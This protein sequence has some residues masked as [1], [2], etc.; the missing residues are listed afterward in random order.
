M[1]TLMGEESKEAQ[2]SLSIVGRGNH[3]YGLGTRGGG[4]FVERSEPPDK[5]ALL[6]ECVNIYNRV[7]Y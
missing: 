2:A 6:E 7:S 4:M 5:P 1:L 3:P